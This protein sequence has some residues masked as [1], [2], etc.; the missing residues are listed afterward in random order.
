M[1]LFK[2]LDTSN[3]DELALSWGIARLVV[4]LIDNTNQL[5]QKNNWRLD[6]S[7]SKVGWHHGHGRLNGSASVVIRS[8]TVESEINSGSII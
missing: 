7:R 8:R 1:T 5:D 4:L 3:D 2:H 6:L